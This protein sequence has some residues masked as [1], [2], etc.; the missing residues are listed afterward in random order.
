[1]L[2]VLKLGSKNSMCGR[3]MI[4]IPKLLNTLTAELPMLGLVLIFTYVNIKVKKIQMVH[5]PHT[6]T[7]LLH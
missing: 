6:S 2:P 1:M 4:M 5:S 7:K 3:K